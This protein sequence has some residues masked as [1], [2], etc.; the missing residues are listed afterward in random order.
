MIPSLACAL[1]RVLC[2]SAL[3]SLAGCGGGSDDTA[4]G[5]QLSAAAQL[6]DKIF[7]DPSLS[8]SGRMACAD[9]HLADAAHA[10]G[11][12]ALVVPPGGPA[13]ATPG[14]RNSPS[15]RYLGAN[16]TFFFDGEGTPTGGF[17]RDGRMDTLQA[18]SEPAFLSAHEMDNGT[19]AAFAWRLQR[20]SYAD[21][22]RR[23]FGATVFD[24]ADTAFANARMAVQRFQQEDLR[25]QPFDSKYDQFLAGR[26]VLTERE[27]RGLVLFNDPTK[28]NCSGCH[29]S[30]RGADGSPPLFTDFTYDNLGVPRNPEIPANADPSYFDLGLCGPLRT[31]LADRADLCG[32]FKVPTLRNVAL[33]APYF[34]NGRFKTLREVVA[35]YVRRDT[36]PEEFYPLKP[37]GTANKFDDLPPQYHVNVNTTEVPYDRK[38]GEPPRLND[39][40]IDLVVEFMNT[41]TD[42]YRP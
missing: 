28:G 14:F 35:F 36:H 41:L 8:S 13:L 40:E 26:V 12:P 25:F 15:L 20:A 29:P 6:G 38:P 9:C 17:N 16:P 10:T 2:A 32:A 1:R 22:L 18:Q 31:D 11:D 30:T 5:G 37:D 33:T 39:E 7:H 23:V 34:H 27:L 4:T 21:E 42:G 19:A 24:D 3:A